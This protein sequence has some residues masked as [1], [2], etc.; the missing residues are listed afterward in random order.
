MLDIALFSH[1][2]KSKEACTG[3][4]KTRHQNCSRQS[5][6]RRVCKGKSQRK[7]GIEYKIQGDIEKPSGVRLQLQSRDLS[8]K[9]IRNAI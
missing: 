8:I 2:G 9:S 4:N 3:A 6:S 7:R 5:V 1:R